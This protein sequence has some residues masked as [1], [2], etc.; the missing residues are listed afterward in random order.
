[1]GE[2]SRPRVVILDDEPI[3]RDL[4]RRYLSRRD[5]EPVATSCVDAA[6]EALRTGPVDAVI[7]DY[8]L[9]ED[10]NGLDVLRQFRAE[11][12]GA[13]APVLMLTGAL[14]SES[15]RAEITRNRGFLFQKPESLDGLVDFLDQ[16]LGRDRPQ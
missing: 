13:S 2:L 11:A 12:P 10:R 5:Y 8:R 1:M 15:E 3:A 7:L 16:L 9:G 6:V 14:L 4:L